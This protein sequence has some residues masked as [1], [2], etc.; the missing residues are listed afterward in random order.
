MDV[1]AIVVLGAPS[2]THESI[3]GLPYALSDVLG[4]P[5]AFRIIEKLRDAGVERATVITEAPPSAWPT[6]TAE[7]GN[8]QQAAG[9]DL[10]R[11]A[12][13]VFEEYSTAG[14]DLVLFLRL[15]AYADIDFGDLMQFHNGRGSRITAVIDETG[16]RLDIYAI[17]GSRRNDAAYLFRHELKEFRQSCNSYLFTGYLNRLTSPHHLRALAVDALMQR[18]RIVPEG[19]QIRPGVWL[20]RGAQVHRRARVLSPA[21]I[22]AGSRVRAAAVVT[23][24]SALE[25]H[26]VVDCGTVVENISTL[27]YT[28]LGAGLDVSHSV[29]G[30]SRVWNLKRNV[31]VEFSDPRLIGEASA[32]APLR[33]L[34][35]FLSL[36]SFL[37]AQVLRGVFASSHRECPPS[38]PD[39]IAT[40]AAALEVPAKTKAPAAPAVDAGEF[41]ANL[42]IARRYGNE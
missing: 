2:K 11:K 5:I 23:R 25:H 13:A 15:G 29:V 20:G 39:S 36:V 26:T 42:A 19:K 24:C 3:G 10:W 40:P 18:V 6:G 14:A 22:G 16:E 7:H 17:T 30:R 34:G 21:Y 1:R 28:Y 41:P 4:K 35:G 9:D 37:P 38:L 8:W 31:E 33:A 27:P 12:E 32:N